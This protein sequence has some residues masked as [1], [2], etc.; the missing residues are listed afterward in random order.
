[1]TRQGISRQTII[2]LVAA[3]AL[4][5]LTTA[6][7]CCWVPGAVR[8]AG[9]FGR[10]MPWRHRVGSVL[11]HSE[12]Q[13]EVSARLDVAGRLAL[14]VHVGVGD[15]RVEA[16]ADGRVEVAGTKYAY[17]ASSRAAEAHLREFELDVRQDGNAVTIEA[18]SPH[19]GEARS[20]R[21]ELV[22]RVPSRCDVQAVVNVGSLEV[23]GV[24]GQLDLT[25]NV[26]EVIA[27][28]VAPAGSSRLATNVG[29]V[30]VRL[31]ASA[32]FQLDARTSVGSVTC[33]FPLQEQH[34]SG[35]LVGKSLSGRV[36]EAP[37]FTLNLRANTGDVR[38]ERH[39]NGQKETSNG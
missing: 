30:R 4:V 23:T 11:G 31:P 1:M 29:S 3:A 12:A 24:E 5:F 32:S 21:V 10:A 18:D 14:Q 19:P 27:R 36:G 6:C 22:I 2:V 20:P 38:V 35:T 26:G 17:G 8:R 33:E 34:T 28:D 13:E 16:G 25:T 39:S 9:S 37:A 15:I 7:T